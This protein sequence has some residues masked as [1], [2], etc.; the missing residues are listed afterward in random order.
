[1]KEKKKDTEKMM[2]KEIREDEG[3]GNGEVDGHG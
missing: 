2:V 1:M 3:E